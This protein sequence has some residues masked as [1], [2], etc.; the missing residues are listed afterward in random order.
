MPNDTLAPHLYSWYFDGYDDN[1]V[2]GPFTVYGWSELTIIHH[3]EPL[4]PKSV[5]ACTKVE[6]FGN[7]GGPDYAS[8]YISTLC[9]PPFYNALGYVWR[10]RDSSTGGTGYYWID[11]YRYINTWLN[12]V[13][14]FN[15]SRYLIGYVNGVNIYSTNV[16]STYVTI[17]DQNPATAACPGCYQYFS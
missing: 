8:V 5:P 9:A 10:I 3:I 1:V 4:Y 11:L 15:S 17:L 13:V 14:V 12:F 2:I 7:N 16:P 6:K